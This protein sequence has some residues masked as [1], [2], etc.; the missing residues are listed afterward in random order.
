MEIKIK[1]F[2]LSEIPEKE[3]APKITTQRKKPD[4]TFT[5]EYENDSDFIL[6]KTSPRTEKLL[7]VLVS[8]GQICIKDNKTNEVE[9]VTDLHQIRNFRKGMGDNI[10][11]FKKLQWLPFD[12]WHNY[13][14]F[15]TLLSYTDACKELMNRKLNPFKSYSLLREYI[16]NREAFDQKQNHIKTLRLI[17]P[18]I[19]V[20]SYTFLLENMTRANITYNQIKDNLNTITELGANMFL[21]FLDHNRASQ[22]FTDYG[23]DFK[24]FLEWLTYTIKNR[25]R[26]KIDR[27]Y[28]GTEY[29][30]VGD[31][32]DYLY[33]Q[34]EMY[35]KVREKYPENWLTEKQIM[36]VK[37]T[38]W[39]KL[40]Q[41]K[42]FGL[43]QERLIDLV[44]YE[45]VK[46]ALVYH[47]PAEIYK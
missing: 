18:N 42:E 41:N 44:D 26:L 34:Y 21:S 23:C 6:K 25:N 35:G 40:K 27:Y 38:E 29:F 28:S 11:Q 39:R 19:N 46:T 43:H 5:L 24:T 31:Y 1:D 30:Y 14:E 13:D 33:S 16:N 22:V 20:Y 3:N 47:L 7:V 9:R 15:G 2:I 8:Q 10:P 17:A 36:N 37:Y 45:N 32:L 12:T 4:I